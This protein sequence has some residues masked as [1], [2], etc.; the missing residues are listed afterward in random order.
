MIA[1]V[2]LSLTLHRTAA[3]LKE[4]SNFGLADDQVTIIKQEKVPALTDN[5]A[6][7]ALD[8]DNSYQVHT[9]SHLFLVLVC[10]YNTAV[11]LVVLCYTT[12]LYFEKYY[13]TVL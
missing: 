12:R 5:E 2:L 4:H 10:M 8:P 13:Y 1:S 7:F 11:V 6:R 9:S 3:L